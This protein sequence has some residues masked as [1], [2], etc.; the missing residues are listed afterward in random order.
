MRARACPD[1]QRARP[2]TRAIKILAIH[3]LSIFDGDNE[4]KALNETEKL[5]VSPE[6]EDFQC[7]KC[8][9]P[10]CVHDAFDKSPLIE[11]PRPYDPSQSKT[12]RDIP[13]ELLKQVLMYLEVENL[14]RL[15][16]AW[17]R[18]EHI[19]EDDMDHPRP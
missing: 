15:D 14:V 10:Q 3:P 19:N 2:L 5:Q 16:Q 17:D 8:A 4:L 11:H 12:I 13:V 7:H 18:V 1:H 9:Y 6:W